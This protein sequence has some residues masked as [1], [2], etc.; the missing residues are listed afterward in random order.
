[1]R[2]YTYWG[3][4]LLFIVAATYAGQILWRYGDIIQREIEIKR[5]HVA[6]WGAMQEEHIDPALLAFLRDN[7]CTDKRRCVDYVREMVFLHS[8]DA[9]DEKRNKDGLL[10][11]K[12]LRR[13]TSMWSEC[14]ANDAGQCVKPQ[15][16]CDHRAKAMIAILQAFDMDARLVHFINPGLEGKAED[17]SLLEV[18]ND[19][20]GLWE[21]QDPYFN[22]YFVTEAPPRQRA[23]ALEM[24]Y[25]GV[26]AFLPCNSEGCGWEYVRPHLRDKYANLLRG[27]VFDRRETA[28]PS[29][30]VFSLQRLGQGVTS[31]MFQQTKTYAYMRRNFA[32]LQIVLD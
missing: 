21:L 25:Q 16:K 13:M 28:G 6:E 19:A 8:E 26:D 15:L 29:L 22:C 2:K 30:A 18:R 3:V 1:M 17:H 27:V 32:G 7:A 10:H 12:D 31:E 24:L 4:L 9:F 20:S 5:Q 11:Y 23:G 14:V